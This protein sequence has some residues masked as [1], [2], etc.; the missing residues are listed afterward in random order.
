MFGHHEIK[1]LDT[2]L[3]DKLNHVLTDNGMILINCGLHIA[4]I[5]QTINRRETVNRGY[6]IDI[7]LQ[8]NRPFGAGLLASAPQLGFSGICTSDCDEQQTRRSASS[9]HHRR[10]VVISVCL[11]QVVKHAFKVLAV[12]PVFSSISPQHCSLHP[13]RNALTSRTAQTGAAHRFP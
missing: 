10:D 4:C 11:G 2:I 7:W 5:P 1:V 13:T 8:C 12:R 6:I 3:L 9:M